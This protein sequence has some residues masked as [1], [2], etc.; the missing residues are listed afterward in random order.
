MTT[1]LVTA[2]CGFFSW[3]PYL[4]FLYLLALLMD[5][6]SRVDAM[7]AQKYGRYWE[8]YVKLVPYKLVPGIF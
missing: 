8:E 2:P 7:C 3:K 5:R 6:T 4:H 1:F